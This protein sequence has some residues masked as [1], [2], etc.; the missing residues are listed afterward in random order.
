VVYRQWWRGS[1]LL[2]IKKPTVMWF[3]A[4]L[5]TDWKNRE[6]FFLKKFW[7]RPRWTATRS[8]VTSH[9]TFHAKNARCGHR[10]LNPWSPASRLQPLTTPLASR[11]CLN[12]IFVLGILCLFD[13]E[14]SI[15]DSKRIQMKNLSTTKF[16]NFSISTTFILVVSPSEVVYKIWISNLRN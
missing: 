6:R 11:L 9:T 14:M 15:W 1:S 13:F 12:E 10:R 2:V 8:R 3:L 5:K 16:Y 4:N 7:E